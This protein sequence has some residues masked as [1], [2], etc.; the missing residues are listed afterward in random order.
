MDLAVVQ[1]MLQGEGIK[2]VMEQDSLK[3]F[4][5]S[6]DNYHEIEKGAG[7]WKLNY[8]TRECNARVTYECKK[9]SMSIEEASLAFLL[10]ELE[11][12]FQKKFFHSFFMKDTRK[13]LEEETNEYGLKKAMDANAIPF[14]YISL[15]GYEPYMTHSVLLYMVNDM[16]AVSYINQYGRKGK[17]EKDYAE[18]LDGM[19]GV[20]ECSFKLYLYDL[21]VEKQSEQGINIPSLS[22]EQTA[23]IAGITSSL[24]GTEVQA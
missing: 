6:N 17:L 1:K 5:Y 10:C 23:Y 3:E 21:F 15:M 13:L 18:Y 20:L 12:H 19:I 16:W 14:R 9:S 22:D 11:K 8:V 2:T 24:P 7:G 4:V